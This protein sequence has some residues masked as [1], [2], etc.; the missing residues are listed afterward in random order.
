MKF[1]FPGHVPLVAISSLVL[2]SLLL[3][4]VLSAQEPVPEDMLRGLEYRL[5]GPMRGGRVN[6]VKGLTGD[7]A[8]YYFAAPAGGL[9]KTTDGGVNWLPIFDDQPVAAIGGF[10]VSESDPN[11]IYV[12]TGDSRPRGNVVHGNGVYKSVD[13]GVTWRHLGLSDS[14][15][16][17]RVVIHPDNPDVVFVSSLGHL[18]G[19]NEERGV[20]RTKDGGETWEKVLYVDSVTGAYDISFVPGNPSILYATTWQVVRGPHQLVSGGPGSGLY[21]S[22]DGGSRWNRLSGRGLP[23]GVLG[24]IGVAASPADPSRVYAIIEAEKG[25][26]Y[27]SD[28]AG[29]SWKHIN[30]S[31]ALWRRAWY[32]MDVIPDPKDAD[33]LFIM[34]I[35]LEKSVDGGESFTPM[36]V[37]HVD[38]HDLWIDPENPKRMISGND[39]GANI[40]FNGGLTW[41][42]SDDNQPIG[43]FYRVTTD[44]RFPYFI[45]GG[46]QD[47][48]TVAIAS[49]GNWN[50]ITQ[51][52]WHTVGGCEMGWVAP[53]KRTHNYVYAGCTDGGVTRY[54][55]RTQRSQSVDPWP[56]TN[57]G[58]GAEDARFRFQWTSPMIIS[59]HDPA[60]LYVGANVLFRS[61]DDGMNW[62]VISPDLTHNDKSKQK[63]SGGPISRDNVGTEVY[64]TIYA[65]A[66]SSRQEGMLWVGSDDGLIHLT[67]DQ[68][69]N[70]KNVTP[71]TD[72]LPE[73]SNINS[74]EASQHDP[75][76]AY[77]AVNRREWDDHRPYVY[78]TEDFG[79]SWKLITN[80]LPADSIVRVIR[81]DTQRP[82]L[83]FLG[84]ELGIYFSLDGGNQWQSL[85][86]NLPVTPV[87]DLKVKAND[88]V[89]ATHGRAFWILD[90]LSPLRQMTTE[91]VAATAHLFVPQSAYRIRDDFA[92]PTTPVGENPPPGAIIYYT[93]SST[94][95]QPVSLT[96][97]DGKGDVI[98]RF[99]SDD[100]S[101]PAATAFRGEQGHPGSE[102][103]PVL[104][105]APITI[106]TTPF[107]D[108]VDTGAAYS[109]SSPLQAT[110]G[111]HRFV[112]DLRY[113]GATGIPGRVV[114]W[115]SPKSPPVGP[116]ALP[117][118]YL[119]T[120]E[121]DGMVMT[122][123]LTVKADPRLSFPAGELEDQFEL[124]MTMRNTLTEISGAVRSLR[125]IRDL[126]DQV[127]KQV[128]RIED[129]A[130][131]KSRIV[132]LQQDL[133][134]VENALTEPRMEG[135]ADAFHYP[136]RLDNKLGLLMGTVAN[137]DR[138]PT[139]QSREV[140]AD[141]LERI[142]D[143]FEILDYILNN[144]VPSLNEQLKKFELPYVEL[145]SGP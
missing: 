6:R 97:T 67:V 30:A 66:E 39:G 81:E 60:T 13:A 132:A 57:I 99:S 75:A 47:W 134:R 24:K 122:E 123:P 78:K 25:G 41:S 143:Q 98:R 127:N 49:R 45:Y 5:V 72:I 46:Q 58:H 111:L 130:E 95:R 94:P 139:G 118:D 117:G 138:A 114:F 11:I 96:I 2:Y 108:A 133:T 80:G 10:A 19:S 16:I 20:F 35:N 63:A 113:P 126:L 31:R 102:G 4:P 120:L 110:P 55:R 17:G 9:W 33:T 1:L 65:I 92:V 54:D 56:E 29:S 62:S 101:S 64:G 70:W 86:R 59:A 36:K 40:S 84:T 82:G 107:P 12:G 7:P 44:D 53:D 18:F 144:D 77:L 42:R 136:T 140:Y 103:K 68:G 135:P 88:L 14:R 38:H 8:T 27:R 100:E 105:Q 76:S 131:L 116:L 61:T 28:D 90:D 51:R 93:L 104:A 23:D 129:A 21:R 74:I 26:L 121:V 125:N 91:T 69:K 141:L 119:V 73:G 3:S 87:Y 109:R 112:W 106:Q 115:H 43:Q 52:D 83:L 50:G 34:N 48:E 85:Q 37:H 15:H 22:V 145:G 79:S 137:S 71:G 32:F 124:H 89:V 142:E 128:E